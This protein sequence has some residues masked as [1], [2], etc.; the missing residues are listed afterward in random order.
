MSALF[1]AVDALNDRLILAGSIGDALSAAAP[2]DNPPAWVYVYRQQIE[3]I[4]L[5]AAELEALVRQGGA[6]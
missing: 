3:A 2:A 6:Q 5:A 4:Q 1:A